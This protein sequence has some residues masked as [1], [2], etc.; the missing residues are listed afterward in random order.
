MKSSVKTPPKHDDGLE[1]LRDIRRQLAAECNHDPFE[2][3]RRL[4]EREKAYPGRIF[5]TKRM[6]IPADAE[7]EE[8]SN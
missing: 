3:G 4:R 2:M 8:K 6:L 1:W 7:A 5:K